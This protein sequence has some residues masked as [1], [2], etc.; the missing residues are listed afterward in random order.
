MTLY[1]TGLRG[2]MIG[3]LALGVGAGVLF[4]AWRDERPA[5]LVEQNDDV[6]VGKLTSNRSRM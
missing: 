3:I 2:I 4:I 5:V 6:D 1:S